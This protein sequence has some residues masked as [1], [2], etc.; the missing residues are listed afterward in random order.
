[1]TLRPEPYQKLL[2]QST[3]DGLAKFKAEA[4]KRGVSMSGLALAWIMSHP[5]VTAPIIGPRKPAHLAP[6]KKP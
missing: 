1:M 2:N 6:F 3:F 5:L 4:D